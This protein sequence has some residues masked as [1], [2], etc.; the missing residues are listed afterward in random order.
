MCQ[1]VV[2]VSSPKGTAGPRNLLGVVPSLEADRQ[3][4]LHGRILEPPLDREYPLLKSSIGFL[5]PAGSE[6]EESALREINRCR[7]R[8]TAQGQERGSA[9]TSIRNEG[10]RL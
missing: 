3:L 1:K 9:P 10:K 6:L 5:L 4:G 2:P 7:F 8:A